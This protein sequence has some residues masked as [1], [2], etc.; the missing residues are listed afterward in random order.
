MTAWNQARMKYSLA[1]SFGGLIIL[2]GG[3]VAKVRSRFARTP[4]G[5]SNVM[6]RPARSKLTGIFGVISQVMKSLK[7]TGGLKTNGQLSCFQLDAKAFENSLLKQVRSS[8]NERKRSVSAKFTF[9]CT[10]NSTQKL[11]AVVIKETKLFQAFLVCCGRPEVCMSLKRV[12][13]LL[14][15][16]EPARGE[17][18]IFEEDPSAIFGC[19]VDGFVGLSKAF[20]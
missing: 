14:Q 12:Q 13:L 16:D 18:D 6:I 3:I 10:S 11:N 8:L 5:G 4:G 7:D 2:A 1:L 19:R 20:L 17:V 15:G 9:I